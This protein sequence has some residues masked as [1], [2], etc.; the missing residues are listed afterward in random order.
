MS[1]VIY[2]SLSIHVFVACLV[3]CLIP[4]LFCLCQE[5][6]SCVSLLAHAQFPL[7]LNTCQLLVILFY[8]S[9]FAFYAFLV[10]ASLSVGFVDTVMSARV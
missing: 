7:F 5:F 9:H 4:F 6:C 3:R 1:F 10:Y 8:I 2:V